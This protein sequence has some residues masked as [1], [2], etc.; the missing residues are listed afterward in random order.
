MKLAR[1]N[2]FLLES[3][4]L[5]SIV[6]YSNKFRGVLQNMKATTTGETREIVDALIEIENN[7][8]TVTNNYFDF[9]L[10]VRVM[11]Y[12]RSKYFFILKT[13]VCE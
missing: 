11:I 6:R 12:Y 7:D 1:Y 10:F 5:E 4:I 3:L 9:K 8:H 2:D 13:W